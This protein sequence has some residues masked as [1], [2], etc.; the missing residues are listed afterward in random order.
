MERTNTTRQKENSSKSTVFVCAR[1]LHFC[2]ARYNEVRAQKERGT[3]QC[4]PGL[5][6]GMRVPLL[7]KEQGFLLL[8]YAHSVCILVVYTHYAHIWTCLDSGLL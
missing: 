5:G 8:K 7:R 1:I 6:Q 4:L 3:I 2:S